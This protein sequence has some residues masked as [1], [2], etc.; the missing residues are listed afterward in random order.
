[1]PLILELMKFKL[2]KMKIDVYPETCELRVEAEKWLRRCR[3]IA[4]LYLQLFF[5]KSCEYAMML[6]LV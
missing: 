6:H 2:M 4:C 1:M 3:L 5:L